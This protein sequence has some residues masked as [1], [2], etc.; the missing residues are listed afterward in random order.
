MFG[1]DT[2]IKAGRFGSIDSNILET[3]LSVENE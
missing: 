3:A 2:E 1:L